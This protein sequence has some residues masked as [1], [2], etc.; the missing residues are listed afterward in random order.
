MHSMVSLSCI[1]RCMY[2]DHYSNERTSTHSLLVSVKYVVDVVTW[3][4]VYQQRITK[5]QMGLAYCPSQWT[6]LGKA[7]ISLTT[8]LP[9]ASHILPNRQWYQTISFGSLRKFSLASQGRTGRVILLI[10]SKVPIKLLIKI[11]QNCQNA[12]G[13][14]FSLTVVVK[15]HCIYQENPIIR[16]SLKD[17]IN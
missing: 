6:A 2:I 11:N 12:T 10:M 17:T 5:C 4:V 8:L 16:Q 14:S 1:V 9:V 13:D 7:F 3:W 15:K